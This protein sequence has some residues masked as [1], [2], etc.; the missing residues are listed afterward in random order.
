MS[1]NEP[2]TDNGVLSKFQRNSAQ[3]FA[4]A[5]RMYTGPIAAWLVARSGYSPKNWPSRTIARRVSFTFHAI[6]ILVSC[7]MYRRVSCGLD[8]RAVVSQARRRDDPLV[9]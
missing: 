4:V 2:P 3:H 1:E 9:L 6:V 8:A 7:L 5:E